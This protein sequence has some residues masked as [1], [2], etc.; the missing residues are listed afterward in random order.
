MTHR[1]GQKRHNQLLK[2]GFMFL[3]KNVELPETV[4]LEVFLSGQC[5][6]SGM[7]YVSDIGA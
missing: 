7:S 5:V 1:I 2:V 3:G 6:D 4:F